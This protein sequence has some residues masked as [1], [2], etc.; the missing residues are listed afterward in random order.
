[1]ETIEIRAGHGRAFRVSEG[2]RFRIITP[3]GQQA[4]DFFAFCA[5]DL[6]ECLSPHHTWMPTRSLHPREGDV[7]LSRKRR[8]MVELVEDGAGGVHD[9]LIAPC[10]PIRYEQFGVPGHRSCVG[11]LVEAM[12]EL[13]LDTPDYPLAVN[14]FT[15]TTVEDGHMFNTPKAPVARP[16]GYVLLEARTDLVCAV[17]SCPY[18]LEGPGWAINAPGGPTEIRVELL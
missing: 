13:G 3:R 5:D 18:D 8:P 10:D 15:A 6:T 4:A 7:F 1:M 14:F 9:L 11:N 16:G 12:A 17:S 2:K